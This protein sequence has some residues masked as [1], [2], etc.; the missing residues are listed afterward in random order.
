M[1]GDAVNRTRGGGLQIVELAD[2]LWRARY[3]TKPLRFT[4]RAVW[5]AWGLSLRGG[6]KSFLA[7]HPI[8]HYPLAYGVAVLAL[9]RAGGGGFDGAA[10][11]DAVPSAYSL[12]I[13][14]LP[15][16]YVVSVGDL[17]SIEM[18]GN[19]R[20]LHSAVEATTADGSGVAT[21]TVEPA[22]RAGAVI[23]STETELVRATFLAAIDW[24]SFDCPEG[25]ALE[26]VS[27]DAVQVL[28]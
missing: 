27:F 25:D 8:R 13:S 22:V 24:D 3:V 10:K 23:D 16:D 5:K 20:S 12:Q 11:L 4:A 15:A 2:P 6:A 7:H 21:V 26:P 18:D 17:I 9:D 14:T 28:V 1:R 19:Q